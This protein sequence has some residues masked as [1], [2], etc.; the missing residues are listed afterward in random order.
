MSPPTCRRKDPM[1]EE[2]GQKRSRPVV[3]TGA[4]LISPLGVGTQETWQSILKGRSGIA[5]ITLFSANNYACRFA[6]EVKGFAPEDFIERKGVKKM[7]RNVD[8]INAT[9]RS[10]QHQNTCSA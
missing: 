3:V 6:G 2:F 5:P 7:G 10:P 1:P 9:E 8:R 4:G